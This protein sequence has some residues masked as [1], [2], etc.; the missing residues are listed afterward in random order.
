VPPPEAAAHHPTPLSNLRRC[1]YHCERSPYFSYSHRLGGPAS[2]AAAS[3]PSCTV[4]APAA[5]LARPD[6]PCVAEGASTLDAFICHVH[7]IVVQ[8]FPQAAEAR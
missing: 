7:A 4:G 1:R 3:A 6:A 2:A 8:H 5:D